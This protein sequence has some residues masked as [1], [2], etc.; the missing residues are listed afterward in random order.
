MSQD[1]L[2]CVW[3][4]YNSANVPAGKPLQYTTY[5]TSSRH[6]LCDRLHRPLPC[7]HSRPRRCRHRLL[8]LF[9]VVL[10]LA[11]LFYFIYKCLCFLCGRIT[12][13]LRNRQGHSLGA[14]NKDDSGVNPKFISSLLPSHRFWENLRRFEQFSL[15]HFCF[16]TSNVVSSLSSRL[17]KSLDLEGAIEDPDIFSVIQDR[18]GHPGLVSRRSGR[19]RRIGRD[20]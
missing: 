2:N 4:L 14:G 19:S 16:V 3:M 7:L 6:H 18:P 11:L 17:M 20:H 12:S 10:P 8:P 5:Y 1:L 15:R 13:C 9:Y